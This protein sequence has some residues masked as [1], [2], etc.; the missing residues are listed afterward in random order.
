MTSQGTAGSCDR[1][2]TVR[3]A[4]ASTSSVGRGLVR[5]PAAMP[6]TS[7]D[8]SAPRSR[9]FAKVRAQRRSVEPPYRTR[10]AGASDRVR[11]VQ[12]LFLAS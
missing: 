4:E 9:D 8:P 12:T 2:G 1:S 10:S 5:T 11:R 7:A 6:L 3:P